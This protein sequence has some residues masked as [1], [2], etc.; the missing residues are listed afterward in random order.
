MRYLSFAEMEKTEEIWCLWWEHQDFNF[1]NT[2]FERTLA[3][4]SVDFK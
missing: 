2:K 3:N 4:N 1:G